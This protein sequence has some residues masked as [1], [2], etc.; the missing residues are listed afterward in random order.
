MPSS[1]LAAIH[2]MSCNMVND[3][4]SVGELVTP[5]QWS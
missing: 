2:Y 3:Q 1:S 4:R 5:M